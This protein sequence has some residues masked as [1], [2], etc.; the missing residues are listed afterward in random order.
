MDKYFFAGEYGQGKILA[1]PSP[2]VY[3]IQ[4]F[5]DWHTRRDTEQRL[6]NV[7]DMMTWKFFDKSE[8]LDDYEK[9]SRKNA[10]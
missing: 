7:A 1:T 5:Y 4:L 9:E 8:D 10:R 6:V 2:S 3:L